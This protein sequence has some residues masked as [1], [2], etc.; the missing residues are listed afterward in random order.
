MSEKAKRPFLELFSKYHPDEATRQILDE[1]TDYS[2]GINKETRD[3]RIRLDF[4]KLVPKYRL[5]AIE[6]GIKEDYEL[7]S[8]F[9]FPHYPSNLFSEG[10]KDE[11]LLELS[12]STS[13]AKG[14]FDDCKM[15]VS[16]REVV[17]DMKDGYA[18]LPSAAECERILEEIICKEFDLR[19]N[20][21]L[22]AGEFDLRNY[23][24][25]YNYTMLFES[26]STR[27][28]DGKDGDKAPFRNVQRDDGSVIPNSICEGGAFTFDREKKIVQAGFMT[29]D[30]S[31]P[32]PVYGRKWKDADFELLHPLQDLSSNLGN[33]CFCGYVIPTEKPDVTP[34]R[35]T[36][37]ER[38][39]FYV[40]D[41]ASSVTVKV[42][43]ATDK[44]APLES[45][46]PNTPVLIQG[47]MRFDAYENDYIIKPNSVSTVK[48]LGRE[49]N[50]PEK[51]VELHLHTK[52]STMDGTMDPNDAVKQAAAWG[53]KAVAITDHGNLQGFP[54]AMLEA[55]KRGI[56]VIYGIEGYFV[57]DTSRA[58]YGEAHGSFQD[59]EFVI[60]D[61]ETTGLSPLTCQITEIG[62]VLYKNGE[63]LST[64]STFVDPG[65]PI[66]GEITELTGITDEMVKGAPKPGQAVKEFLAF[67]GDRL[68][69][70]HNAN[71]DMGFIKKAAEDNGFSVPNAYL[72]TLALSRSINP[73]LKKHKLDT[74]QEY[75]GLEDFNHH[76]AFE[77][78]EMLGKIFDAMI[79]K[80]G[81]SGIIDLDGMIASM[82]SSSDPRKI[83]EVYHIIILVKN[84]VGLKNLYKIVSRSYLDYY[85]RRPRIPKTLL[86][87][88]REGLIVGSACSE[89]ELYQA[90]LAGKS[91]GDLL[92]ITEFYDYLEVQPV[93][94]NGYLLRSGQV[95][96]VEKLQ[97][98][99][100]TILKLAEKKEKLVVATGDVHFLNPNDQIGR[101]ILLAG[102]KMKGADEDVP[103]YFRTTDEML[104]EFAYL[105]EDKA[106]ELVITNPN[107]IADMIEEIRPIP[108]GQYP[109]SIEGAVEELNKAC[110]E[111]A[112]QMYGDPLPD[113]VE[114]RLK[115]ELNAIETHGFSVLYVIARRLV[116]NSESKGYLVGSRGSVGSSFVATMGGI[117]EVNPLVPHY[118]CPNPDCKHSEFITDGSVGS[119]FDLDPKECPLCGTQMKTDGHDIPFETFLG[120][121][122]DKSPDIDLNFSGDVQADAHAYT[123]EL[124]GEG[125]VF[126]AG[127]LGTLADKNAFGYVK[128][129]LEEKNLHVNTATE[130]LLI[131]KCSGVKKTT[132]QHPGGIIV[133]PRD[134]DVYDFTPVQHPADGE[135]TKTIT[136]HFAFKYLHD[137]VLKLDILGHDVPT[138]YKM[139][140]K[141]TGINVLSVPM[142]DDKVM[143][144]F[145]SPSA[146]NCDLSAIGVETGT[147][148]L[149]EFGTKFVRQMLMDTRP[150]TFAD[151]LQISGL[152]HGTNVW[153]GNA[154]DLIKENICTISD[155]IGTRDDI[156]TYLI[157]HGMDKKMSFDIMEKVRK[158]KGLI[159]EWEEEMKKHDVPDWYISSCKKIKYMFPKAHAAAYVI[160]AIRLAW[161]KVYHPVEFYC[162]YFSAAP[163]G[164][165]QTL[166]MQGKEGILSILHNL[167]GIGKL[168]QKEKATSDA[169]QIT[170]EILSRGIEILPVNLFKSDAKFF[171]PEDG[172]IR[173]PFISIPG[174]GL[175]A[176]EIIAQTV[177]DNNIYSIEE[178]K[179]KSGMGK[180]VME[181]L[182]QN[183][184]FEGMPE[185]NQ[186]SLF[187]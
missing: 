21:K 133:I 178:F 117:S 86:Q 38:F 80:M 143:S 186:L 59:T 90:I 147:L 123:E 15:T 30:L 164:M 32:V 67:A 28:S 20:V 106:K 78:A 61:I 110:Y 19:L 3:I 160:S 81:K 35:G 94:N 182:R 113:P 120:F 48:T 89:G 39:K 40:S 95:D 54:E 69:I 167:E 181:T 98:I 26:A 79:A 140:E 27:A 31:E 17:F 22:Q 165:D 126:R 148:C 141:Y 29:F 139:L 102:M 125:N 175:S 2:Y 8:C 137:T 73:E 108:E 132:G 50:A 116:Q 109:P 70:A 136:T 85:A 76:R 18:K 162:A 176:A 52:M 57:D 87:E 129:Y 77:D 9:I 104:S 103:L 63:V 153:L 101:Q 93:G 169:M 4:D 158:G 163:E 142:K 36:D 149:P 56:K 75:F 177:K 135:G 124:F 96:S 83:R 121:F 72:D 100:K 180:G 131:S 7:N 13:L 1:L 105:G 64:F 24:E 23:T 60:F 119:G 156:M 33:V 157:Y 173:L 99:N 155:V 65:M 144:L 41:G 183:G 114:D 34:M 46:M 184:A 127:T 166:I 152:S 55:K 25:Q 112:H 49:D 185:T 115:R 146:L 122:G 11:L 84:L 16:E 130:K 37:G 47:S 10:Y 6:K 171:L 66:P 172:K 107:K 71:F 45:L 118:L 145:A 12:R 179:E 150:K 92:R 58:I 159:P 74:L 91:F 174:L 5:Y 111:K 51:R 82:A 53:H 138:K 134:K 151:L 44:I 68:L 14:F 42:S 161:F 88:Y 43:G 62:A 168:S 170:Y 187:D 97:E 154:Q 128:K